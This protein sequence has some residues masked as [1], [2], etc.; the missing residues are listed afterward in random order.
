MREMVLRGSEELTA[1]IERLQRAVRPDV[2]DAILKDAAN[3][4]TQEVKRNVNRINRVTGRL[5]AS[6][7][8]RLGKALR[9]G[10]P[11]GAISFIRYRGQS[12]APHAHLVEYGG[13]GGQMPAQPYFRPAWDVKQAKCLQHI[14]K[15]LADAI[16][17]AVKR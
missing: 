14:E 11:K 17:G 4:V 12:A 1:A 7:A 15:A 3:I 13:R 5:R 16:Q 10:H 2:F 6:P 9:P 8:T